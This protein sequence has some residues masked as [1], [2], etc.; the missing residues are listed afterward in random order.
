VACFILKQPVAFMGMRGTSFFCFCFAISLD[1]TGYD[2]ELRGK[3]PSIYT[4]QSKFPQSSYYVFKEL[5]IH[6]FSIFIISGYL[7]RVKNML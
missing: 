2:E 5:L 3:S 6:N 4:I 1:W 7:L